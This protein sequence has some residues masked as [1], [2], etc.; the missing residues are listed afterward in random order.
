MEFALGGRSPPP[1]KPCPGHASFYLEATPMN[2]Y[3]TDNIFTGAFAFKFYVA[4]IHVTNETF[5][6]V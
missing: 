2:L 4:V 1:S 6:H 3:G 5:D